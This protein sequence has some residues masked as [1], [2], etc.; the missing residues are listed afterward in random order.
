MTLG[1]AA[2]AE[3]KRRSTQERIEQTGHVLAGIKREAE[4]E[5]ELS[6]SNA[7]KAA[8]AAERRRSTASDLRR[9][10]TE[11]EELNSRIVKHQLELS[12]AG[13]RIDDLTNS[14]SEIDRLAASVDEEKAREE[15]QIAAPPRA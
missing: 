15:Q 2:A 3:T 4:A 13:S 8:A 1:E 10:E 11:R 5:S 9:L 12:E 7:P 14:I 6:T